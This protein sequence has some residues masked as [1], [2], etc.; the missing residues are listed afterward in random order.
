MNFI[1]QKQDSSCQ[2]DE[3]PLAACEVVRE[4]Q[5]LKEPRLIGDFVLWLEQRSNEGGR[6]T[7]LLRPWMGCDLE[8]QEITPFPINVRS[9]IHGYGGGALSVFQK[10]NL[11]LISWIDDCDGCLWI[12]SWS[13]NDQYLIARSNYLK[14]L[15]EPFCLSSKGKYHLGDG[16]ID[17]QRNRWLGVMEKNNKDYIIQFSLNKDSQSPS[18]LYKAKDFLGYLAISPKADY[19]C[20]VEWQKP[21]MPWDCSQIIVGESNN[22][23]P[24]INTKSIAGKSFQQD[25]NVSVFQPVWMPTGEIV[26]S[27]DQSGWWNLILSSNKISFDKDISWYRLWPMEAETAMPQWVCGISTIAIAG[28]KIIASVCSEGSWEICVFT[29]DGLVSVIDQPFNDVLSLD[30]K[31]GRVF[32]IAG[33]FS[34]NLGLLE[35]DLNENNWKYSSSI[36]SQITKQQ[37]SEPQPFWFNGFAN[38]KTHSWY[39][40][41]KTGRDESAPLLVKCHSGPTAMAKT[42]LNLEIQFWTSRGWGVLDVNY[43][44]STGFGRSYRERLKNA[45]GEVDVAD[46]LL[47]TQSLIKEGKADKKF[48]AIEGG[49]AGGF[50]ALGCLCS[51]DIFKAAACKYAVTDLLLMSK[52]THRFEAFYL[53]YL[54]GSSASDIKLYESKSPIN[55][56]NNIQTPIIFFQ[57]LKDK[58]VNPSQTKNMF[59]KLLDKEIPTEIHNFEKEGHGFKEE[60]SR[61][62]VLELTEKFFIK[63]LNL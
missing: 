57:G 33:N 8:P 39:Y 16:L 28:E 56:V 37:I 32:A 59:N 62:K 52:S 41:P 2:G 30:A 48:I 15:N 14:K 6:I 54:I 7:V 55:N 42:S 47:A 5:S 44:G 4:T 46:C 36:Q 63:H 11:F 26:A 60:I 43:G 49:S 29:K 31:E 9:R 53:N 61:I 20:W 27:D 40:P 24:I 51:S 58:V 22:S 23:G 50:T 34:N 38:K 12:Q 13:V 45:W 18:I 1:S 21:Y 3:K 10:E 19:L 25:K 17:Y 35:I